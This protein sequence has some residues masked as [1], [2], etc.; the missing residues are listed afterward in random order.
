MTGNQ[1]ITLF[2]LRVDQAER[3]EALFPTNIS[4]VTF[5]DVRSSGGTPSD[6]EENLSFKIRIPIDA[7]VEDGRTYVPEEQ[8]RRLS[9]EEAKK[10]W[11]IQK[12]SLIVVGSIFYDDWAWD[13][14][15]F[16]SGVI[17]SDEI[18]DILRLQDYS[19]DIITVREYAD[20]TTRGSDAVKHWRIGGA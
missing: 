4:G 1:D 3:R 7:K 10:H 13:D 8:Y 11:T 6:R 18:H 17:T 15:N 5:Y 19:R 2:N 16:R 20:N 14:F 9:D 12:G